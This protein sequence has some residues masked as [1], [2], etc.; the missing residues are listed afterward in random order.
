MTKGFRHSR[1]GVA[2]NF[3]TRRVNRRQGSVLLAVLAIVAL[4]SLA[5]WTYCDSMV[6]EYTAVTAH[7]RQI[8]QQLLVDSGVAWTRARLRRTN[9]DSVSKR[10]DDSNS[11]ILETQF[12]ARSATGIDDGWQRIST[13]AGHF[14][15][16]HRSL[17]DSRFATHSETR[18]GAFDLSGLIDINALHQIDQRLGR[19]TAR[20][21]LLA[22]PNMTADVADSIL[23]F[24]A[25][26]A[27]RGTVKRG[28]EDRP[29][30]RLSMLIQVPG[31]SFT[32]LYGED[33]N[34]NGLL[35]PQEDTN[36]DGRLQ[37]GW[38]EY[39]TTISGEATRR[40]D[41]TRKIN[42]NQ[43]S[44]ASL[45]DQLEQQFGPRLAR[46]VSAFRMHGELSD[47][48]GRSDETP[49][50]EA[51]KRAAML[52]GQ[53]QRGETPAAD[54]ANIIGADSRRGG[55]DL[56][57]GPVFRIE[58]LVD[59]F[60]TSVR[61]LVDGQDTILAAPW[62]ADPTI[63]YQQLFRLQHDLT[64]SDDRVIH[65]RI[66]PFVAPRTVLPAIP[67]ITPRLADMIVSTRARMKHS[68][69]NIGW[70][71]DQG[72]V[73]HAELR[74]IAPFINAGGD[75]F[76]ATI[77]AESTT[78]DASTST[79]TTVRSPSGSRITIDATRPIPVIVSHQ[80]LDARE[81]RI[82]LRALVQSSG[83]MTHLAAFP[84]TTQLQTQFAR[85]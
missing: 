57:V 28:P 6:A 9:R 15:V 38:S 10:I 51:Q 45:Y 12:T 81:C 31:V 24:V 44:L 30:T 55:L 70:L 21:F 49:S 25:E 48:S 27:N 79:R 62:S 23:N 84:N 71:L 50:A 22:L 61:T 63:V 14:T 3:G 16:L 46:F 5:A 73:S 75:Y 35:D 85:K 36:D 40:P 82:R 37:S 65:G 4:L 42:L 13:A 20:H 53:R 52:R 34:H 67:G 77:I 2:C 83:P 59:L 39:L 19:E 66:N 60:G 8:E 18:P 78:E 76:R 74:R 7:A 17:D 32:D 33:T 64:I 80:P 54:R 69:D 43:D 58:S 72:I 1:N 47:L 41:G 26:P 11:F 56:S 29:I 68:P